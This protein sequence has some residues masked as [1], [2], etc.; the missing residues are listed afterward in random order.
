MH[1]NPKMPNDSDEFAELA[2][3]LKRLDPEACEAFIAE[4]WERVRETHQRKSPEGL[5]MWIGRA[6]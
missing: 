2:A 3:E 1:Q 6:S 5:A 4:G